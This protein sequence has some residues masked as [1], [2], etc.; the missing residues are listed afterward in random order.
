MF[1]KDIERLLAQLKSLRGP[2]KAG[3]WKEWEEQLKES[4]LW[5][6]M[7][8]ESSPYGIVV[9]VGREEKV[10]YLNRKFTELFGYTIEDIPDVSAWW[11]KA[12]PDEKYRAKVRQAWEKIIKGA[13]ED[14]KDVEPLETKVT[15][16]DGSEK[17]IQFSF[18]NCGERNIVFCIDLTAQRKV[19]DDL[20]AHKGQLSNALELAHL[21]PWEYDVVNDKFTF[22]DA[23]YAIFHTTADKVGGY[24][25][26]AEQYAQRFIH[27]EDSHLV[28][29]E[30]RKALEANDPYFSRSLDHRILYADGK[31]GY[32]NVRFFIVKDEEGRT[33]RTYGVNQDVTER[34]NLEEKLQ[35][36]LHEMETF[37]KASMNREERILELK[38]RVQELENRLAKGHP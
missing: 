17:Y 32:I 3:E 4:A 1:R 23:F 13:I 34:K 20:R 6:N 19:E 18:A 27:P 10:V 11:P 25:M 28:A 8:V 30:T 36:S 16:K 15:C 24:T 26:N 22:N 14:Q 37:Y 35:K 38:K 7:I 33:I 9:S 12:Y 5:F 21:G 31:V 29:V 2:G